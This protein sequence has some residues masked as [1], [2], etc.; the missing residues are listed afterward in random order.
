MT[1]IMISAYYF[2]KLTFA[3]SCS[4]CRGRICYFKNL[5][6]NVFIH[7]GIFTINQLETILFL[8]KLS[9]HLLSKS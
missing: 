9:V 3:K 4:Y 6:N 1:K 8:L 5:Q 2:C 7:L